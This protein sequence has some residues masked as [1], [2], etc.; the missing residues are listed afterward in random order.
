MIYDSDRKGSHDERQSMIMIVVERSSHDERQRKDEGRSVATK[1][2]CNPVLAE[3]K[4]E[5][6]IS[7]LQNLF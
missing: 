2:H 1:G 7:Y 4:L 6:T 3:G 5:R